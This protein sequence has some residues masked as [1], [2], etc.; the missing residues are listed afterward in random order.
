MERRSLRGN[1]LSAAAGAL[2]EGLRGCDRGDA[3]DVCRISRGPC[4]FFKGPHTFFRGS[5]LWGPSMGHHLALDFK[6]PEAGAFGMGPHLLKMDLK[7]GH[8]F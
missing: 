8:L 4:H 6:R 2:P 5:E 1:E 3:G 7:Y